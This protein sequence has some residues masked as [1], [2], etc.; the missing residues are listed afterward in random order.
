MFV[1]VIPEPF[2]LTLLST[3]FTPTYIIF[4]EKF[5]IDSNKDPP[6]CINLDS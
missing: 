3:F 4:F 2:S 6:N 5:M 1:S